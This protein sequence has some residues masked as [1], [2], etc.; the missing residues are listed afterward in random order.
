[1]IY[2]SYLRGNTVSHRFD[3]EDLRVAV[4]RESLLQGKL[5]YS[6]FETCKLPS[7]IDI[8]KLSQQLPQFADLCALKKLSSRGALQCG[9]C[10]CFFGACDALYFLGGGQIGLPHFVLTDFTRLSRTAFSSLRQL[11]T[12][13]RSTI[14]DPATSHAA[15]WPFYR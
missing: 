7:T 11:K 12:W 13:I 6:D 14:Y 3:Q 15:A 10:N 2:L 8:S 1:M 9:C 4:S 5:P